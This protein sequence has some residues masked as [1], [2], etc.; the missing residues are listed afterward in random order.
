MWFIL[1]YYL[2]LKP[3]LYGDT[4]TA[5]QTLNMNKLTEIVPS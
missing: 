5:L 2:Y 4:E 1:G 3:H